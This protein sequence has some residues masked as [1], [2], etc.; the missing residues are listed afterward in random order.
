MGDVLQVEAVEVIKQLSLQVDSLLRSVSL[1]NPSYPSLTL[2]SSAALGKCLI[3]AHSTTLE[4]QSFAEAGEKYSS[5]LATA[6]HR[7]TFPEYSSFCSSHLHLL[8]AL[9]SM[10]T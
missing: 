6:L 5:T 10:H 9:L 7:A 8:R 1:T 4:L 3:F 2:T